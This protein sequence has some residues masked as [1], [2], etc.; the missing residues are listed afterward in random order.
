MELTT[1]L[2]PTPR[3]Y[4]FLAI[5]ALLVLA[6]AVALLVAGSSRRV[7]PPFGLAANGKLAFVQAGQI[8]TSD[9]P[10]AIPR[11]VTTGAATYDRPVFSRDGSRIAYQHFSDIEAQRGDVIVA[12]ADGSNSL[13]LDSGI[14]PIGSISWSPD[15]RYLAY[16]VDQ[17]GD[18]PAKMGF[19]I[20]AVDGS[21]RTVIDTLPGGA[22]G[23]SWSPDGKRLAV[24]VDPGGYTDLYVVDRDGSNARKLNHIRTK[25]GGDS[26]VEWS[27]DGATIAFAGG[28]PE[29]SMSVYLVGLDGSPERLISGIDDASDPAFSPDGSRLAYVRRDPA[30][31]GSEV[32]I[33]DSAGA[34]QKTL[35]GYYGKFEPA[36]SPDG[37]KIAILSPDGA[38]EETEPALVVLDVDGTADPV[39]IPASNP[40]V[41]MP[42]YSMTWQRVAN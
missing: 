10:G 23:P 24:G 3:P 37:T 20:R 41:A 39:V 32:V 6:L 29:R 30:G 26:N 25:E 5:V 36:W 38:G 11:P 35:P 13:V 31:R 7:A 1:R 28:D 18:G 42:E 15:S 16:M 2:R 17:D 40:D 9:Y 12:D 21:T 27:P 4:A 8:Y 22:W 19:V 14:S 33:A 34:F